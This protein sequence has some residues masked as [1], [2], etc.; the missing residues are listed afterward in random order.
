[1]AFALCFVA[2][3]IWLLERKVTGAPGKWHSMGSVLVHVG[4]VLTWQSLH[5][6]KSH[7]GDAGAS[8]K[9]LEGRTVISTSHKVWNTPRRSYEICKRRTDV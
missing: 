5:C 4:C 9:D 8:R 7:A 6:D 2:V 1:M 3:S